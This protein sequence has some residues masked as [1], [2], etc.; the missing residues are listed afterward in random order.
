MTDYY[1]ELAEVALGWLGWTEAEALAADV[2]AIVVAHRGR[3]AM[4]GAVFGSSDG[5]TQSDQHVRSERE[6]TPALYDAVFG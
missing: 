5:A 6:M 4:L 1:D 3:V 2:N